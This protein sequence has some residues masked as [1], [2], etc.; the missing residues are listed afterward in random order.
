MMPILRVATAALVGV[1]VAPG[2]ARAAD[3]ASTAALAASIAESKRGVGTSSDGLYAI[4]PDTTTT[5]A[6]ASELYGELS[7]AETRALATGVF[8]GRT[9]RPAEGDPGTASARA[10]ARDGHA[11]ARA[12]VGHAGRWVPLAIAFCVTLLLAIGI[13][14]VPLA[15]TAEAKLPANFAGVTAEDVYIGAPDYQAAQ[16][17]KQRKVGFTTIRQVFRWNELEPAPGI[18]DFSVT[19]RFV[20]AAARSRVRVLPLLFGEPAW[21]TS[22]AAGNTVRATFPPRDNALFAR[23]AAAVAARYGP[24]GALWKANPGVAAQ[25]IGAY[26]LWN[27]PNLPIYWGGKVNAAAYARLVIAGA[28]AI[29]AVQPAALIVS[30]GLPDS[31]L[32][33]KPKKFL[34]AYLKAG[35]G[36]ATSAVGVH[37]Y[38]LKVK[39]VVALT[40]TMRK[41]LDA[42]KAG[43]KIR[44]WVTELGWAAGGPPA[45]GRTVSKKVQASLVSQSFRALAK[46]RKRLK[47][48][49]VIYFAWRDLP[50]YPGRTDFWGLRTGL[51]THAGKDKPAV[52]ALTK[53]IK[54]L[55]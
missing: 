55:R 27:E 35:G 2:A 12:G 37:P 29:R 40:R 24:G 51:L 48:E 11:S 47:L 20:L 18:Y 39:T 50:P 38:A 14:S 44:L 9:L 28:A 19:D 43:R 46:S 41:T 15:K 45:K 30:G 23:F 42:T 21:A 31:K 4:F 6:E 33:V 53:T 8:I 32:G 7:P 10:A 17:A 16:F 34:A 5:G 26:Q 49:G 36:P 22:R 52:K 13:L 3:D 54:G 25:P 1:T